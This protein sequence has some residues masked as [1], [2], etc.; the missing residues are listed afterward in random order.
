MRLNRVRLL[1]YAL[2]AIGLVSLVVGGVALSKV[3]DGYHSLGAYANTQ[4]VRLSYNEEGQ[5]IDRGTT[6]G[7]ANIMALLRDDWGFHVNE[8]DLDADDPVVDTVSE[9][10]YQMATVTYHTLHG[11][12]TVVLAEDKTYDV[13]GDGTVDPAVLFVLDAE[14]GQFVVDETTA[15]AETFPAGTYAVPVAGRYYSQLDRS[16]PL[17]GPVRNQAWSGLTL[18]LIGVLAGG[19]ATG[20]TIQVALGV[21]VIFLIFGGVLIF[22]GFGLWWAARPEKAKA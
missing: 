3:Q 22:T 10:M 12:Q 5:L 9:F 4:D 19:A 11:T 16:H 7:A 15:A 6:E 14:T 20:S 13:N 17:E 8:R 21:A 2:A 1:G 18:A